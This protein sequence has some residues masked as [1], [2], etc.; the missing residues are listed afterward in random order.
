MVDM[1]DKPVGRGNGFPLGGQVLSNL[2]RWGDYDD[3]FLVRYG[4]KLIATEKKYT[5]NGEHGAWGRLGSD[6]LL[7]RTGSDSG[8]DPMT[9][10]LKALSNS[11]DAATTF[12]NEEFI[13]KNDDNNPFERDT[14]GNGRDGKVSL[15][16]FQYLFE[17]RDWPRDF[18]SDGKESVAGR[19][20]LALAL[21]A[22]TTGH[23]AG[24]LS[25]AD[26]PPHSKGQAR[27][28]E[29]L[30]SSIADDPERLTEHGYMTDSIGQIASEYLPD[31]NRAMSDVEREPGSEKWRDIEKLYPIA[32]AEA[33][34]NHSEVTKLLFTIGQNEEGYAAVEVGQKAYMGKLM[35]HHLNP[36][37]PT[38]LRVSEDANLLVRQIATRSGEVSGTLGLGVQ[39]A[40]GSQASDR[41]KQ[42]EHAVAQR[43][44]WISGG[45]GTAT[46]VGL[47]FVATPWVGAAVGGSAGTATS[48]ILEAVFKDAEGRAMSDAQATG[49]RFWAEG[50]ERNISIAED[51]ART[52]AR[53]YGSPDSTDIGMTAHES[54]RQGYLNARTI[55]E[56]QAPG[57]LT[58]Y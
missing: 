27:L 23:A 39:E 14:D 55:L 41:D 45:I 16:N 20:T 30:V 4:D 40:I 15:S 34:L 7:N 47:S 35:D 24:E 33:K 31:M 58:D 54:A 11:P 49:G 8:W 52:A 18:T 13:N 57:S 10:Y 53:E 46:G 3:A 43:K 9:G 12:F 17:E 37:L 28:M 42:F 50:L 56:G 29:S 38:H 5:G 21:E 6:P 51:A 36:D 26:T 44:N 2:M 22:A 1:V 32:G 19:N 25:T 48:V